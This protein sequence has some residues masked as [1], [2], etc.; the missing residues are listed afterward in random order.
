[1]AARERLPKRPAQ[2]K[3]GRV[4]HYRY[5]LFDWDG[6]LAK[7]LDIWL[8]CLKIPLERRGYFL[9]DKEIGADFSVFRE[10]MKTRELR[11]IN[12]IIA[13]AEALAVQK[14]PEVT[15]YPHVL[16][17]LQALHRSG[18]RLALVT[19]S[20]HIV[21]DPLLTRYNMSHLFDAVVCG[22][23]VEQQKPSAE[24]IETALGLLG[25][26]KENALMIGDSEKDI[27]AA[28]NAGIDSLL[29]HSAAHAIFYGI[30]TLQQLYPTF[31]V[32]DLREVLT[33][34]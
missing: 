12:A 10:R 29:F 21:I 23:D 31:V 19:T 14:V 20:L 24:P 33:I 30:A 34:A 25:G 17:V 26:T 27:V 15:L 3:I 11:D 32:Q 2:P 18:K 5:I 4:T 13:E 1:M 9:P 28:A 22:D 16:E 8:A 6:S 7:T